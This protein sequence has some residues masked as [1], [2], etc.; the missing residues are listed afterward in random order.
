MLFKGQVGANKIAQ[1]SLSGQG[2]PQRAPSQPSQPFLVYFLRRQLGVSSPLKTALWTPL[3][4]P[5]ELQAK[6]FS[7]KKCP[8]RFDEGFT[9]LQEGTKRAPRGSKEGPRLSQEGPRAPPGAFR[10]PDAAPGVTKSDV[11]VPQER[12]ERGQGGY[13]RSPIAISARF[14]ACSK[15][16]YLCFWVTLMLT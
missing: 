10:G 9:T 6:S 1:T 15:I 4:A 5:T 16:E 3:S 2:R 7:H 8:R 13:K 12:L 11:E 14:H